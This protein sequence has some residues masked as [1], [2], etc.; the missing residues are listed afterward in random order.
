MKYL[1]LLLLSVSACAEPPVIWSG[2]Y[3]KSLAASG[4]KHKSDRAIIDLSVDPTAGGGI[5]AVIGSI[6]QRNNGGVGELWVKTGAGNTAWTL[7]PLSNTTGWIITGNAGLTAGTNFLGT[8]DAVDLVFKTNNTEALR[9]TSAGAYDT[10]LGAGILHSDASG[11][12]TSSAIV[13]ADISGSAAID[14]TKIADGSVTNT[15]FQ[16]IGGLTSDAQTQLNNKQPLDATLTSLSSLGTAADKYAYT[17]GVD[18][19][20]EGD[21]TSFSRSL[22]DDSNATTAR[23]TLGLTIGTDVQA[24]DADLDAL[25]ALSGTNTI[26]YRSAANT[27]SP[28][29]VG[30]GL[31]F[32]AGTLSAS[33]GASGDVVGPASSTDNALVRFD[34]T[35]GKLIQDSSASLSDAGT[36]T[37]TAFSGPLTG[38]ASTA[39]A[40][41]ANPT[42]CAAG[43]YASS[44]DAS[45]NLTC[46]QVPSTEQVTKS[47]TQASHG[48]SVGELVY[49]TG[50][51]YAKAKADADSTS[52]VLGMVSAVAD[53]NTFSLTSVG[54]VSGL[55]GLTAGTTY[56]LSDATAGSFTA[57][58]PSTT[59][60]VNK[61]VFVADSTTSAYIIQSRG[62]V[63]GATSNNS[64]S[65]FWSGY[66]NTG[67]SWGGFSSGSFADFA[68]DASCTFSTRLNNGMGTVSSYGANGPGITFTAP[69]TGYVKVCSTVSSYVSTADE[70]R[71]QL[72]DGTNE[73]SYAKMYGNSNYDNTTICGHLQVT[74]NS[75]YSVRLRGSNAGG[76]MEIGLDGETNW[77]IEYLTG[78]VLTNYQP[79]QRA[80]L[81][82]NGSACGITSQSGFI[83]S[84]NRV[85]AGICDL[86]VT[87][88]SEAPTCTTSIDDQSGSAEARISNASTTS[89]NIRVVTVNNSSTAADYNFNILCVGN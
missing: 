15:E 42:D 88:F 23:S 16:Y 77:S 67:C 36:L 56:Y 52:E 30:S 27:W 10:T 72:W 1:L 31:S 87:G 58:A 13:N 25:A 8:T 76:T 48:F 3:T 74:K 14:A 26:Y 73:L 78:Y 68:N 24:W 17:T 62:V 4:Y 28:V 80:R 37:A 40:L 2:T 85:S 5:T 50:S 81:T 21:I 83:S 41:A 33:G 75:S 49:Y 20:V 65:I 44:I 34:G 12:L 66:H 55:S 18:T 59:G 89:T 7:A 32:S 54:Y 53:A 38:N 11:I 70:K 64:S 51:A 9:I 22:L 35:T 86:T 69:Q 45:G 60:Y 43:Q 79:V 61:P 71:I 6:G 46:S 19:W 63:S 47:I 82:N 57:T 84:A 39:T 29:T